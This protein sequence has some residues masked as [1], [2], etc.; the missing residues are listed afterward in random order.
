MYS[1]SWISPT[2]HKSWGQSSIF[3]VVFLSQTR[4]SLVMGWMQ[5][6]YLNPFLDTYELEY[7]KTLSRINKQQRQSTKRN[8]FQFRT[9]STRFPNWRSVKRF[10]NCYLGR[11]KKTETI[12]V[13][14]VL[15]LC[16][17]FCELRQRSSKFIYNYAIFKS[18]QA[19]WLRDHGAV[20]NKFTLTYITV[21]YWTRNP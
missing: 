15:Y 1:R 4:M 20:S 9:R 6:S 16:L 3:D 21:K 18:N 14:N 2:E 7:S 5:M 19:R 10:A 8:P 13:E 11:N 17:R 12:S